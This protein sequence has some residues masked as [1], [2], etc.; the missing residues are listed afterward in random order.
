[1]IQLQ[2]LNKIIK[3]CDSSILLLNN[4]TQEYFSDYPNEY[5]F[6]TSHLNSYGK[7]PDQITFLNKFPNFVLIDVEEPIVC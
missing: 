7:V 4:L 5:N 2:V 1:M 3:D 6:I